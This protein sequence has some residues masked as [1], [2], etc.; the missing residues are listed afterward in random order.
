MARR[1][2]NALQPRRH[3]SLGAILATLVSVVGLISGVLGILQYFDSERPPYAVVSTI[4][5]VDAYY[6]EATNEL[7]V[8]FVLQFT[9]RNLSGATFEIL[10]V[11]PMRGDLGP[12]YEAPLEVRSY[13]SVTVDV[14]VSDSV[15]EEALGLIAE[16]TKDIEGVDVAQR[17]LASKYTVRG[18]VVSRAFK[19]M[20]HCKMVSS[21]G[22]GPSN[23][24]FV[25]FGVSLS[26]GEYV[27][28]EVVPAWSDD[29]FRSYLQ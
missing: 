17:F 9:L 15:S 3:L 1:R 26:I 27:A 25:A 8:T 6:S 13:R 5:T 18:E 7:Y 14:G 10:S 12:V 4:K 22:H 24:A 29:D 23:R 19:Y 21:P 16:G 20:H 2:S 11:D 28:C